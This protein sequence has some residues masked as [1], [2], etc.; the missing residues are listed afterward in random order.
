MNDILNITAGTTIEHSTRAKKLQ[1]HVLKC[2]EMNKI[3][4][5]T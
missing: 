2:V 1:Q 5:F 4:D 3:W